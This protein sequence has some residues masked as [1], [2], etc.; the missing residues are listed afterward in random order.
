MVWRKKELLLVCNYINDCYIPQCLFMCTCYL[1]DDHVNP[2][3]PL[4]L[5]SSAGS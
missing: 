4:T 1:L 3:A 2:P 5:T